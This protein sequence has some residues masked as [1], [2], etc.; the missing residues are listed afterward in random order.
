MLAEIR[1]Y[2][3]NRGTLDELVATFNDL[4]FPNHAAFGI[5]ILGLWVDR[6]QNQVTWIRLFDST[7]DKTARLGAYEASPARMAALQT[8]RPFIA[9]PPESRTLEDGLRFGVGAD[10]TRARSE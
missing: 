9:K 8:I 6:A 7:E 2:T 4:I 5:R 3:A 10:T 1:T